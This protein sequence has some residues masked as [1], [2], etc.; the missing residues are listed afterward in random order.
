[1]KLRIH[2]NLMHMLR[3]L[4]KMLNY[5]YFSFKRLLI[6]HNWC[7]FKIIFVAYFKDLLRCVMLCYSILLFSKLIIK[8]VSG[9][10][11][12]IYN[13]KF[14]NL[15]FHSKQ[16]FSWGLLCFS[17][18]FVWLLFILAIILHVIHKILFFFTQF[19]MKI[20]F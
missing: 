18:F 8:P 5:F 9:F 6:F 7:N 15:I 12:L 17:V 10:T 4:W 19:L 14:Y 13:K 11:N 3:L 2:Y 20:Y 16:Y 1:M